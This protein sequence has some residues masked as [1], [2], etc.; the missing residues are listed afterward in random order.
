MHIVS[1]IAAAGSYA[2][3]VLDR[4]D[5][6][7]ADTINSASVLPAT[8]E[9]TIRPKVGG[10]PDLIANGATLLGKV[11]NAVDS[12]SAGFTPSGSQASGAAGDLG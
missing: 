1:Q 8:Q 2:A 10:T 4:H 12:T 3:L 5:R 6:C 7:E 11:A 9:A